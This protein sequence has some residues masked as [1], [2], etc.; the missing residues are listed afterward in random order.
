MAAEE[1]TETY[2]GGPIGA[3][4]STSG[5]GLVWGLYQA[6][7]TEDGD[8]IILPEFEDISTVHPMINASGVLNSVTAGSAITISST[9]ANQIELTNGGTYTYD[10]LVTGT[11]AIA[12]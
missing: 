2:I 4:A 7:C 12:N 6:T 9:T 3:G 11:K 10:L 5:T 8:W 1:I